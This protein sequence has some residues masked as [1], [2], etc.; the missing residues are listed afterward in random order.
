MSN[1]LKIFS[2]PG[3]LL[4]CKIIFLHPVTG[5]FLLPSKPLKIICSPLANKLTW[6]K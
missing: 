4:L 1:G 6:E 2:L 3:K 5:N